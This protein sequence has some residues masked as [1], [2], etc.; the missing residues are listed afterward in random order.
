MCWNLSNLA[1]RC[2]L[3]RIAAAYAIYSNS[4]SSLQF[5]PSWQNINVHCFSNGWNYGD[6]N[7]ASLYFMV[8]DCCTTRSLSDSLLIA[9]QAHML[10]LYL[11]QRGNRD[12]RYSSVLFSV[13]G[14]SCLR[15][16]AKTIK[17][18][19]NS[20]QN[21]SQT[22]RAKQYEVTPFLSTD[23]E[24]STETCSKN[25]YSLGPMSCKCVL[26]SVDVEMCLST[27]IMF[28]NVWISDNLPVCSGIG[29][30]LCMNL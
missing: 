8:F 28:M 27:C 22:H 23:C 29:S 4:G 14:R 30:S 11:P 5:S 3:T 2:L 19:T 13:F 15:P 12:K 7:W 9:A 18:N 25:V 24:L 20:T 1:S 21:K 17:K 26:C 10:R 6:S 16:G